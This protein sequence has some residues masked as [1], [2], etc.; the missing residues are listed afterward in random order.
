MARP[1]KRAARA[2]SV[3][4]ERALATY[5]AGGP[6]RS[7]RRL[8][9]DLRAE[10]LKVSV[11]TLAAWSSEGAWAQ[12]TAEF[13]E[14]RA[15]QTVA[16]LAH[17]AATMDVRQARLGRA[18]IDNAEQMLAATM[19]RP[20]EPRDIA[21]FAEVGVRIER[22]ATGEATS[23]HEVF[24]YNSIIIPVLNLF[25]QVVGGLPDD[26]RIRVTRHFADG[27]N[28]IKDRLATGATPAKEAAG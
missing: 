11:R 4:R 16:E 14:A 26:E 23:R 15:D 13:D 25:Q 12:R 3:S 22:L 2:V 18:L 7:L 21:R 10:G 28:A 6:T 20:L 9:E 1:R 5:L 27:V 8:A 19:S 24:T 17:E